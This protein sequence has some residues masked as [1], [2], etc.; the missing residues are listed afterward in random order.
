LIGA[1]LLAALIAVS[2]WIMVRQQTEHE[3]VRHTLEVGNRLSRVLSRLQDAEVGQRG[4]LLT[5]QSSYLEPYNSAVSSLPPNSTSSI[6]LPATTRV[7]K[8]I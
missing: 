1:A 6:A 8:Q 2:S 7:R 3:A 4:Y 5:E